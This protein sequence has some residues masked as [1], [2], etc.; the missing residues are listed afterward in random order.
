[1]TEQLATT[2]FG[3]RPM[4]LGH[5]SNQLRAKALPKEAVAHKWQ[6]FHDIR[7]ARE[8]LGATDRALAILEALLTFHPETALTSDGGL[9]VFPSNE[10]LISRANGMSP[11]TLRRHLAVLVQCGLIIRRDSPNGKRYA[12]KGRAGE[13]EQAYGFDLTPILARASEFKD[14]A[15]AVEAEKKAFKRVKEK[16]TIC[17]R[18]IVKMIAAGIGEGVPADWSRF[19]REYETIIG[20][21]PRTAPRQTLEPIAQALEALWLD[22]TCALESFVKSENSNAN[23]SHG[24]RH[25]HNSNPDSIYEIEQ[26]IRTEKET[27]GSVAE[28]DNV[29]SLPKRDL[30]LGMVLSACPDVLD[31]AKGREIRTWRD[32][33]A[34]AEHARPVLGISPSAWIEARDAMGPENAAI[35]VASILQRAERISSGGGYLRNLTERAREGKFTVWP[36]VMAL[37]RAKLEESKPAAG[38]GR[39]GGDEIARREDR[40]TSGNS[41]WTVSPAL[42]K[43][44]EK[45]KRP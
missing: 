11:A 2:P 37:L 10:H 26:G 9:V 12:R 8:V 7:S 3:R 42:L 25:I 21:L 41:S 18:D 34:A 35:A 33:V 19:R 40:S 28:T 17:R 29:R 4:T 44:L 1:M 27:S 5:I 6:V 24:E 22:I 14:L 23:E 39:V 32:F 13:I 31:Y 43:S 38:N 20:S 45:P 15:N 30:P 16:L 36:M